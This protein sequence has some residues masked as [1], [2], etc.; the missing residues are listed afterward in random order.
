M[1]LLETF[2][3]FSTV[4][5]QNGDACLFWHDKWLQ[6]PLKEDY[7]ELYSFALNNNVSVTNYYAHQ[8]LQEIYS[9]P[10]STEA[11]QQFQ[12]V[13]SFIEH[14]P[15]TDQHDKSSYNWGKYSASKAYISLMGQTNVPQIY[16]WL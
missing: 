2:K 12:L 7:P 13:H 15:L 1:K 11:F 10:L 16:S 3:S 9:L 4:Q 6:Q 5:V 8:Q 14:F